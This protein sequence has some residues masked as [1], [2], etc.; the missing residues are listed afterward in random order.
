MIGLLSIYLCQFTYLTYHIPNSLSP[1]CIVQYHTLR[2]Q[3]N[4]VGNFI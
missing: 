1:A 4:K 2:A 3:I